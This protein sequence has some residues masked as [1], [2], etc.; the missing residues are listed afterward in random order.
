LKPA[1]FEYDAPD[2]VDEALDLLAEHGDDAKVLAGGQ[3]L[4][5]LMALRLARPARLVDV[6]RIVALQTIDANGSLVVGAGV[7]Q[8]A[9]ERDPDLARRCPPLAQALPLIAHIPIR[10]RGTIGGSVAHADPAAELPA[11]MLLTEAQLVARSRRA[12]ERVVAAADFFEGFFETTLE[13]DELLVELRFPAWPGRTGSAFDELTRRNGDFA[14]VGAAAVVGLADDGTVR[15]ARLAFTGVAPTPV[16]AAAA[17]ALMVGNA[18]TAEAIAAAVEAA[19]TELDPSNDL[20]A[21]AAYRRHVAGLL[22]GRVLRDA[23][24]AAGRPAADAEANV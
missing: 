2:T 23:A 11:V 14:L 7:R 19:R 16:R 12:G 24:A 9:A 8:R 5:P 6:G 15:D 13:P 20:H 22:A 21:T 17:E 10:T 1:P 18:P 4:I 3:S